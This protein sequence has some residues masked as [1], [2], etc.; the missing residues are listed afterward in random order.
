MKWIRCN[1]VHCCIRED[2]IFMRKSG[3]HEAGN[4]KSFLRSPDPAGKYHISS[5]EIG[6]N[7]EGGI[8]LSFHPVFVGIYALQK[9]WRLWPDVGGFSL[10]YLPVPPPFRTVLTINFKELE[11][12]NFLDA[13][14]SSG[15][16]SG[17]HKLNYRS[18]RANRYLS[19]YH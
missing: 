16:P 1:Q 3:L 8:N 6:S 11:A 15:Q 10:L 18:Y 2:H 9:V 13:T 19:L 17:T 7:R 5:L 14:I 4:I 12:G